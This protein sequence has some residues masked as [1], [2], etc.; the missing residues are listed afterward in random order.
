MSED[1]SDRL[2]LQVKSEVIRSAIPEGAARASPAKVARVGP[3]LNRVSLSLF[4]ACSP[5]IGQ[6]QCW[7]PSENHIRV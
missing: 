7:R 6:G 5:K 2:R 4:K 3:P 1:V